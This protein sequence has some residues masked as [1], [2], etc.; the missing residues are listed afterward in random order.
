M[1]RT[2]LPFLYLNAL[3]SFALS[4]NLAPAQGRG[5]DRA[6]R[7][8]ITSAREL[9]SQGDYPAASARLGAVARTYADSP[10]GDF[11]QAVA[12]VWKSYVDAPKLDA[13]SRA[14]DAE[15]EALLLSAIKKAEAAKA[16]AGKS[17]EEEAEALYYLG[18]AYA[19]RSRLSLYQNHAIPAARFAR[20]AQDS[21][22]ALIKL[23]PDY[24]DGYYAAG[25][26]LYRVGL[27]T[28]SPMGRLATSM[29]G[30]KSLPAGDRER[31]LDYL[32][33]AADTGPLTS[34]DAKLALLE[35]Y[36]FTEGRPDQALAIARELQA[37]YPDNQTFARY[38]LRAYFGLKDRA[39]LTQTA[40]QVLAQVRAGKPN[41]G[42]FMKSE[43]ERY[44]AEANKL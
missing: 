31:G 40:R 28:D 41:F 32:K 22:D 38:L 36:T 33:R 23:D 35:I 30:A 34:V 21:L 26:I 10:A 25:S 7:K 6:P 9:I 20:A 44:L 24:S 3:V 5:G 17:K 8:E 14:F 43:A 13:G 27:L 19:I 4:L 37:K 16:R 12:L 2:R 39:K 15:V 11:Y 18:S 29:L 42:P 1:M